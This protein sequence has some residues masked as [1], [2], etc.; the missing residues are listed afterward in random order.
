V[1]AAAADP[2]GGQDPVTAGALALV[3]ARLARADGD[4]DAALE[5]VQS[6]LVAGAA[7]VPPWLEQ[8]L[9]HTAT[10]LHVA[11]G[12]VA[13]LPRQRTSPEEPARECLDEEV[14][15]W[16]ETA[17]VE[18]ARGRVSSARTAAERALR[19]AEV[20]RLRR[21]VAEAQ[22]AVRAFVAAD[23][24][25]TARRQWLGPAVLAD[26][27]EPDPAEPVLVERLT[28]KEQEVLG[29]LSDL[30]STEEIAQAMFVSV[31][32]VKS[33]VRSILRKLSA[34]RRNEAVRRARQ[35]DLL[36]R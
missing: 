12:R 3:R 14:S 32:T 16:L 13:A 2:V 24:G 9:R 23:A 33:H 7:G 21:P 25:L 31:N 29:Y 5:V 1:R 30:L 8:R 28:D 35:L 15:R 6:A 27:A 26:G 11:A 20:E 22:P 4:L 10:S 18:L 19:F 34:T 36:S 17:G